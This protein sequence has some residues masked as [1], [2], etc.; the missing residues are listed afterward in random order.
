MIPHVS[1]EIQKIVIKLSADGKAFREI[2]VL[3]SIRKSVVND[4]TR[5]YR[6][7]YGIE[8]RPKRQ[9]EEHNWSHR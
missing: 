5:K 1:V 3:L 4:I 6:T 2:A 7:V 8:D 9:Q